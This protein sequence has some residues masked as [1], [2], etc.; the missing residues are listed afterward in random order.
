MS[1]AQQ[2][3]L[4]VF[5][6]GKVYV[7]LALCFGL[8]SSA[9]VFGSI[10]DMLV[11]IYRAHGFGP[12]RK[13]VDDFLVIRLPDQHFTED[14][15]MALT[16]AAGVPWSVPK[17]RTF[18]SRQR[19]TGFDWDLANLTVSMPEEKRRA[20]LDLLATWAVPEVQVTMKEAAALHGKLVHMSIIFRLIRPF[21]RSIAGFAASF[22]SS[23]AQLRPPKSLLVDLRWIDMLLRELPNELPLLPSEPADIGWWGDASSSFGIGIVV[24]RFWAVWRY[25]PGVSVGPRK[26]YDIGWAEALAVELGST[27]R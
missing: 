3:S 27:L 13:W 24:G 8:A 25:T 16:S 20:C 23:R 14:D 21:T 19:F 17:T 6:R 11:A 26:Q 9:G 5:W 2:S 4:C 15:F 1:P 12:I 22:R 7:D 10:A 18:A